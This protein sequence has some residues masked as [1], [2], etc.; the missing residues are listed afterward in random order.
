MILAIVSLV[1]L[2]IAGS[3]FGLNSGYEG[4]VI[5]VGSFLLLAVSVNIYLENLTDSDDSRW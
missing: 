5:V 4:G 1:G 2:A 3:V